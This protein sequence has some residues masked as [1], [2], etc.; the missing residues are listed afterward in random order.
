MTSL[1][2]LL[3]LFQDGKSTSMGELN[4]I[5]MP[6]SNRPLNK[7]GID[8]CICNDYGE[9]IWAKY[10]QFDPIC[11][12][13]SGEALGLLSTFKWVHELN[14]GPVDFELDSEIV[15]DNF[16]SEKDDVTE[17]EKIVAHFRR[18]FSFFYPNSSVESIRQ[19]ANEVA[20]NLAKVA[21]YVVSPQILVKI[22]HCIEHFLINKML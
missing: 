14:L 8:M 21:I 18:L 13:R 22:P 20:H 10:D 3:K 7:V 6:P 4:V 9:C 15:V 11:D 19:Q 5:L 2:N 1:Y 12:V 16:H 17:F